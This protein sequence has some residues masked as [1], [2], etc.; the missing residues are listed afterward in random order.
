M[1]RSF[2][3]YLS[4]KYQEYKRTQLFQEQLKTFTAMG[5]SKRFSVKQEDLWPCLFDATSQTGFDHHY[6][7]QSTLIF[8]RHWHFAQCYRL[9][10][11]LNFMIIVRHH[12]H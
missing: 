9:L 7:Y 8:P 4:Q 10:C 11:R 12:L 6:I 1:I 5:G 3:H 2:K